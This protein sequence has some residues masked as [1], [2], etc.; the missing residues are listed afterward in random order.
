MPETT[1]TLTPEKLLELTAEHK[2]IAHIVGQQSRASIVQVYPLDKGEEPIKPP[3]AVTFE[4]V[5]RKPTRIEYKQYKARSF[6][7][8]QRVDAQEILARQCVVHPSREAF[9]ALL[10]DYPAIPEAAG[11]AFS[12]LMGLAADEEGK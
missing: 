10:E 12:R 3:H 11:K 5:F 2:R 4:V 6:S 8:Q 9:D 1:T 7:E